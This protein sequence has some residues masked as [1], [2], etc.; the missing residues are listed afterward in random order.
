MR[1]PVCLLLK[2]YVRSVTGGLKRY[3]PPDQLYKGGMV[4]G[5][6]IVSLILEQFARL[7]ENHLATKEWYDQLRQGATPL[8]I[9][10]GR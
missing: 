4:D 3:Y 2:S 1:G 7:L 8:W 10:T 5:G 9:E 6:W